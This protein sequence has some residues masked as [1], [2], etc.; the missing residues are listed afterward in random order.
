MSNI[1]EVDIREVLFYDLNNM[2]TIEPDFVPHYFSILQDKFKVIINNNEY[3][4]I[5]ICQFCGNTDVFEFDDPEELLP[6]GKK[7]PMFG[8][9][10]YCMSNFVPEYDANENGEMF[11]KHVDII[12]E[13]EVHNVEETLVLPYI[14]KVIMR[15]LRMLRESNGYQMNLYQLE[16]YMFRKDPDDFFETTAGDVRKAEVQKELYKIKRAISGYMGV[17]RQFIHFSAQMRSPNIR[18]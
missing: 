18:T 16:G 13:Q 6:T 4:P 8:N 3:Y 14:N 9:K 10:L 7:N 12:N 17:V 1:V 11:V 15:V 2:L 5:P